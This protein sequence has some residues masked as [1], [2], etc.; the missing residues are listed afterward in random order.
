MAKE[1]AEDND[2]DYT[3]LRDERLAYTIDND[4]FDK[5]IQATVKIDPNKY[6]IPEL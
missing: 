4:I 2:I 6:H 1:H 5:V 3:N